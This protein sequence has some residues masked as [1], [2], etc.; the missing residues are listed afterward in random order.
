MKSID[1]S[2]S[3]YVLRVCG[4]KAYARGGGVGVNLPWAWYLTKTIQPAQRRLIVF[5][6]FCLLICR[7]NAN[8][9]ELICMQIS[10]NI[11]NGP[12]SNNWDLVGISG[13]LSASRN[14]LITFCR[15]FIHYACLQLCSA[16]VWLHRK[17]SSLFCLLW[18]SSASAERIGY[19]TDF[20]SIIKLLQ[21]L[22]NSSC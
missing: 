16:I 6:Y 15:P 18:L 9:T 12:K 21:E 11:V 14:H 2:N 20:C 10:R 1:V 4:P 7:F 13:L 3:K 19:I 22:K 8:T 17:Q 5:A